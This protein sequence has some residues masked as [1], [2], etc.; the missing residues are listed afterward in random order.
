MKYDF[1]YAKY[2]KKPLTSGRGKRPNPDGWSTGP[3][4]VR[5]DK[6]YAYLKHRAQANFRSEPYSLTW[7]EWENFWPDDLWS[8]R[9]R[10]G[11]SLVLRMIDPTQGW[12]VSNLEIMKRKEHLKI[13]RQMR[14]EKEDAIQR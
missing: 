1:K 14:K 10:N 4:P 6:Y 7:E 9:G 2:P 11:D 3:D 12:Q 5:H 13:A 8:Q